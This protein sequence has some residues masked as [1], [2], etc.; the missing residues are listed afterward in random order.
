M[1]RVLVLVPGPVEGAKR[2]RE[3]KGRNEIVFSLSFS[4]IFFVVVLLSCI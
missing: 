3:E 1:L 4:I 2:R